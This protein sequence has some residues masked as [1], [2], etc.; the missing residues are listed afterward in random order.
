MNFKHVLVTGLITAT[1]FGATNAHAQT[2]D[3]TDVPSGHWSESSINY[4]ADKKVI[5]G[6]G[7]GKFGFGDN[8]TRGQVSA[9]IS[10]Y[11]KLENNGSTIKN[12]SDI[13]GHMFENSIKAVAQAGIMTGDSTDKF[14]PDDTLTRYEM[15]VILQKAFHLAVKT[16]DLF[17]DVSNN[18]WATDSVR[19]LYSN[20]ITNGIGN[21]QYGG[22]MSVTR[23]QFA[24]FMYNAIFVNPN[25]VPE[26]IPEKDGDE[27][28]YKEIQ[29]I[30]IDYGFE[31]TQYNYRYN[32]NYDNL[33]SFEFSSN[34][35]RAYKIFMYS[36][37]PVL[38][39]PVKKILKTLLPTK[40]D[41]LYNIMKNPTA[42]SRTI[43]LDGRKVET[44][45]DGNDIY[46][47]LGKRKY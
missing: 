44:Y 16:N 21:Y 25:F 11:L 38:N 46:A 34:D 33:M 4:L 37:D 41:Y 6:Y 1:L 39:E 36:D 12:F 14:R 5:S 20:G 24:K 28:N 7:N 19:S 32:K 2:A 23:E 22:E 10:R 40:G 17:Y 9:I 18:H 30:L 31:K 45:R 29:N 15:A 43:E 35:D 26:S 8:V 47:F 3:F 13:H 42:S 27:Q